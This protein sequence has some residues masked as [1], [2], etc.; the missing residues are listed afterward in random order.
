MIAYAAPANRIGTRYYGF[1]HAS[2]IIG[3][4]GNLVTR[5]MT[6][7]QPEVLTPEVVSEVDVMPSVAATNRHPILGAIDTR[8]P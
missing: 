7:Q 2:R 3:I 1:A 5:T 6:P 8:H 4:Q